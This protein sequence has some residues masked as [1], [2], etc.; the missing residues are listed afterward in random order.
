MQ[1]R[2]IAARLSALGWQ[3]EFLVREV[4][5]A[6]EDLGATVAVLPLHR[7]PVLR[8]RPRPAV[9]TT[10]PTPPPR[11]STTAR[12]R[13]TPRKHPLSPTAPPAPRITYGAVLGSPYVARLLG[14]TL[15]AA[16]P[17][18]LPRPSLANPQRVGAACRSSANQAP[19]Q[20][21]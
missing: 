14:G 4:E 19:G 9:T 8:A 7:T 18:G 10:P 15:T 6:A 11:S 1:G 2:Q 3:I 13:Q 5:E 20:H 21:A 17:T 16:S 12:C